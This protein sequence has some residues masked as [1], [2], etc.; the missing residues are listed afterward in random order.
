MCIHPIP[1]TRTT[2]IESN[3]IIDTHVHKTQNVEIIFLTQKKGPTIGFILEF[4]LT[5]SKN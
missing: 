5:I 3:V 4:F 2:S 1:S